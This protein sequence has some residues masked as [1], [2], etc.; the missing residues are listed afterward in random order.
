MIQLV[1]FRDDEVLDKL[2]ETLRISIK[3]FFYT[4]EVRPTSNFARI[5][6][7]TVKDHS[8]NLAQI[9]SHL[10]IPMHNMQ[11]HVATANR[12]LIRLQREE[13]HTQLAA[14]RNNKNQ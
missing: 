13:T 8:P 14:E 7:T 1:R 11:M 5:R 12:A 6:A 10:Q 3:I 2:E 4:S 9:K